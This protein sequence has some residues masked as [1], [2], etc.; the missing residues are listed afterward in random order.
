MSLLSW[1]SYGA[2]VAAFL[3]VTL[4][5]AQSLLTVAEIIEEHSRLAKTIGQRGIYV[6]CNWVHSKH[7]LNSTFIR[8]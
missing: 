5:L 3:F 7:T 4:A 2:A 6:R 1:F 8:S